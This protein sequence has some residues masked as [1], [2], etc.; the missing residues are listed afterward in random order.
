MS[1]S[2]IQA[3][4]LRKS[5]ATLVDIALAYGIN[6]AKTLQQEELH[7]R[8]LR[9]A[10]PYHDNK[11]RFSDE[12][13]ASSFVPFERGGKEKSMRS[14]KIKGEP[15]LVGKGANKPTIATLENGTKVIQKISS[16]AN[17]S[18]I[19]A[20][21][22]YNVGADFGFEHIASTVLLDD[23]KT[24]RQEFVPN[25]VGT[26]AGKSDKA[27]AKMYDN[28]EIDQQ[29]AQEV[30]VLDF[31]MHSDDRHGGNVMIDKDGKV[32]AI[33][34]DS[35]S[36]NSRAEWKSERKGFSK[37]MANRPLLPAVKAKLEKWVEKSDDYAKSYKGKMP[38]RMLDDIV[39][40][41]KY[42]VKK[43]EIP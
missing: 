33:D 3:R 43:G 31:I 4:S 34:N 19:N 29:S 12:G 42:V 23:G 36:Y 20:V 7:S 38:D 6:I 14:S 17:Q 37:A 24:T 27:M 30:A 5:G 40:R 25:A 11:G 26:L 9:K 35:Y 13:G 8:L 18:P 32:W 39:R 1:N 10:N 22:A 15:V 16:A 2:L 28:K 21:V 41:T